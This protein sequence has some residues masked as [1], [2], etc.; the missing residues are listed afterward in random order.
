MTDPPAYAILSHTWNDNEEY[1]F[2]DVQNGK[3]KDKQGYDKVVAC[4][5]LAASQGFQYAWIDTCGIDK[6]SSA[7]LSEAINSMFA[8]Y[9]DSS[10]CYDYL[11]VDMDGDYLTVEALRK[12]RW[13]H[14]R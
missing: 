8:W 13:I 2:D 14:R 9:R 10:V 1:L 11:D 12:S 6:S 7:E 5:E 3:G 4:C